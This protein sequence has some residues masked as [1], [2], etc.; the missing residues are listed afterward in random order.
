MPTTIFM[1][2]PLPISNIITLK[3]GLSISVAGTLAHQTFTAGKY[4]H[5]PADAAQV[6]L[7]F[8]LDLFPLFSN[9][10]YI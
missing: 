8:Q 9:L 7:A 10:F 3:N 5:A 1:F 2:T 6:C 4:D